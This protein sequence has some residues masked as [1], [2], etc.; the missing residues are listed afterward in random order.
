MLVA[1]TVVGNA[2]FFVEGIIGVSYWGGTSS[3]DGVTKD[4]PSNLLLSISP[5]V[6]YRIN[7]NLALGLKTYLIRKTE[8]FNTIDPD[9]GDEVLFERKSPGW[10]IEVFDRYKIWGMKK[11]SLLVESSLYMSKYNMEEKRGSTTTSNQSWS[12]MGIKAFP[13]M[14][15]DLSDRFSFTLSTDFL[16]MDLYAQTVNNKETGVK[17]R[18]NHFEFNG[19]TTILNSLSAITIG[20]IY[21]FKKSEK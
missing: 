1:A 16:R 3:R 14:S 17:T 6:G 20:I 15:Y 5:S 12:T 21:H 13:L 11:F 2:Q 18:S 4:D 8:R 10:S 7:E 9:T 19:Q